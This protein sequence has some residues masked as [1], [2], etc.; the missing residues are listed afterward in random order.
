[1]VFLFSHRHTK[2]DQF[3]VE[4]RQRMDELKAESPFLYMD[5]SVVRDVMYRYS[6]KAQE[7]FFSFPI[8]TYFFVKFAT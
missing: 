4:T 6:K 2:A 8:E 5:F 7:R 3:I 1:M